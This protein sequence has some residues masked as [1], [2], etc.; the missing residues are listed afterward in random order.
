MWSEGEYQKADRHAAARADYGFS[1]DAVEQKTCFGR[2]PHR[3]F[4]DFYH[5]FRAAH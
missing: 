3:S 1:V 5:V 4:A 2:A